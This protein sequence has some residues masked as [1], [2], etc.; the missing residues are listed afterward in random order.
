[1]YSLKT[2]GIEI[3]EVTLD[4]P[5]YKA[6]ARLNA[7]QPL[8]VVLTTYNVT[9]IH[10]AVAPGLRILGMGVDLWINNTNGI[11]WPIRIEFKLKKTPPAGILPLLY[12]YNAT[13]REYMKCSNT[14]Y[15]PATRTI[16]AYLTKEEYE[17]GIGTP[18]A[19][20]GLPTIVGGKLLV[21]QTKTPD[22][23]ATILAAI[24]LTAILTTLIVK[25]R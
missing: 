3:Y 8:E 6:T 19:P 1:M 9:P 12:Y 4:T 11:Q 25:K 18:L 13:R 22:T 16:W 2:T 15:D 21:E 23:L 7:T 17:A 20:L 24:T 10:D 14:G 5:D